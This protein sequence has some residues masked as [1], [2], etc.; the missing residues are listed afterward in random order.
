MY[1]RHVSFIYIMCAVSIVFQSDSAS[2]C[3]LV[4]EGR[5]SVAKKTFLILNTP[6][7]WRI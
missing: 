5:A 4:A 7:F 2:L 6:Q 3:Q 1:S